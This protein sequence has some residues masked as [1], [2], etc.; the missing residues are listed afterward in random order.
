MNDCLLDPAAVLA[1]GVL[2]NLVQQYTV[3]DG[4]VSGINIIRSRDCV[5][6]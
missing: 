1:V 2:I 3:F 5:M 6:P 4:E